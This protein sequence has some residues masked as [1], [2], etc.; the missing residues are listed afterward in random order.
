MF[1]SRRADSLVP[2]YVILLLLVIFAIGPLV[3]LVS[4]AF[5]SPQ[6]LIANPLGVPMRPTLAN[7]PEAWRVGEFATTIGNSVFLVVTT[8]FI[9]LIL[10]GLAAYSLARLNPPGQNGFMGYMLV[11]STL[12]IWLFLVPLFYMW[13]KMGLT[14]TLYGLT[15]L[16]VAFN[17]PFATFLLRAFMVQIPRDFE[18][19]A[20]VDGANEVSVFTRVILPLTW[21]GFLTVGLVVGLGVWNEFQTALIFTSDPKLFPVA[22]SY[23]KF[24]S[25]FGRDW[26]LTSAAAF[27]MIAP[28]L[29]LFLAMQRRFIAGLS[30]GGIKG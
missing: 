14:N 15:I 17:A 30:Q 16:Y 12:P 2:N 22:L 29:I 1:G 27:M 11:G 25:R 8:V 21:P 10:T 6:E 20:R 9:E 13:S 18:D 7:F 28:V 5:K 24:T 26:S 4:N 3:I 19:A 23:Y